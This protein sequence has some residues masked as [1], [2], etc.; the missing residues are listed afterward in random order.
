LEHESEHVVWFHISNTGQPNKFSLKCEAT[1]DPERFMWFKNGKSF[2]VDGHRVI[3]QRAGQS[4][5]ITFLHPQVDDQGYYQCSVSNIYGV[6]MSHIFEVKT[7]VLNYF[8]RRP[9]KDVIVEE[10]Q[11]LTLECNKPYGVPSPTIF[12]LYR[13]LKKSYAMDTIHREHITIDGDGNLQFSFVKSSDSDEYRIYQCAATS[14]VLHDEYRAGDEFR[15]L[16]S[17]AEK[18]TAS[19][20][21]LWTSPTNIVLQAGNDLHLT[22]IFSGKPLPSIH[23]SKKDAQLPT[24]RIAHKNF[25]KTLII[26]SVISSDKGTYI[27]DANG[28]VR[29]EM[30]VEI[31]NAPQWV[32]GP[33]ADL[34][35]A[36][37]SNAELHCKVFG[38]PQPIVRWFINGQPITDFSENSRRLL[39]SNGEILK[40]VNLNHDV[41]TAVYQ[42]NASNPLGYIFANA[43]INVYAHAPRFTTEE[44]EIVPTILGQDVDLDCSVE[45]AP[46]P[47]VKWMDNKER[48]IKDSRP[49]FH[50]LSN[51]TLRISAVTA[52]DAGLYFCHVNNKYGLNRAK[53]K[54]EVY[55]ATQFLVELKPAK[56]IIDANSKFNLFCE[57]KADDRLE[58]EYW[59]YRDQILLNNASD[60]AYRIDIPNKLEIV[61]PRGR[62]SGIYTCVS[63]TKVDTLKSK[64][65]LIVKDVPES[66]KLLSIDCNERRA[67]V[68]WAAAYD[69]H[70]PITKY[71]VEYE[72]AFHKNVWIPALTEEQTDQKIFEAVINLSPWVNYT[73]RVIASN[74]RGDGTPGYLKATCQTPPSYPYTNPKNVSAAGTEKDNLVIYWEPMSKEECNGERFRYL[75]R[76][77][78]D[79]PGTSWEEFEVEDPLQDHVVIRD[80]PTFRKYVVQVQAVNAIGR[81][82]MTPEM[83]IGYSGQDIP[84]AAP[85]NVKV[86]EVINSTSIVLEWDH[87]D[88]D[89]VRGHFYGYKILC[90]L[91]NDAGKRVTDKPKVTLAP[92]TERTAVL[93]DLQPMSTYQTA[94]L[95]YNSMHDGPTSSWIYITTP[96][97]TPSAVRNLH[98]KALGA[99]TILT[100]WDAP[101]TARGRLRGYYIAFKG[102]TEQEKEEETWVPYPRSFYLY[103]TAKPATRYE[104]SIWAETGGGEGEK[105]Y[106]IVN[107]WDVQD[108]AK[109]EM[110]ITLSDSNSAEVIWLPPSKGMPGTMFY[111]NYS[112]IGSNKWEITDTVNVPQKQVIIRNLQPN[113]DYSVVLVAKDGDRF[114]ESEAQFFHTVNRTILIPDM[115]VEQSLS[116]VAWFIAVVSAGGVLIACLVILYVF[117]KTRGGKYSG[118]FFFYLQSKMKNFLHTISVKK[119]ELERG[120]NADRDEER[121][122]MEYQYG[123][124]C[125]DIGS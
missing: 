63:K 69:N 99:N 37:E 90:W 110:K 41:D 42:C 62:H 46:K 116:G 112:L 16:V 30:H 66:P 93:K 125:T 84:V 54:L 44:D 121:T 109:P 72:T 13:D 9:V 86:T 106:K 31:L 56:A 76:Y 7:G 55:K 22:C 53:R 32:D 87:V 113:A 67:L 75:I 3:W 10:G 11:P 64:M 49:R 79:E 107:T 18:K 65:Q 38:D 80:Q 39:S 2:V 102:T 74:K 34:N 36:E 19:I 1:G 100:S 111:V 73:F 58:I 81:S 82:L 27:C 88:P 25:G 40:I 43:F 68:R 95:A 117:R 98:A 29:H 96:E 23:W 115:T 77:R 89:S 14:P 101:E 28:L 118:K 119:K 5:S 6:A 15:L 21:K 78:L 26:K 108:P 105:A 71:T 24:N 12:W 33:P 59:W 45:A 17:P 103:E 114:T 51:H 8:D 4:G 57:A 97:G 85:E 122:F 104:I 70:E 50:I 92:P 61:K 48:E 124:G 47:E 52:K 120:T 83:Y 94:V 60:S 123:T 91:V 20:K 35:V